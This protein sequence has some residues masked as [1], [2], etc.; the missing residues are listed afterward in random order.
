MLLFPLFLLLFQ[1]CLDSQLD[2]RF[3]VVVP[4]GWVV[5]SGLEERS[6][7][8]EVHGV[9]VWAFVWAWGLVPQFQN[10]KRSKLDPELELVLE[11]WLEPAPKY[12]SDH[13][14]T[15]SAARVASSSAAGE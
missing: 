11:S 8:R 14:K 9:V 15:A 7:R 1:K 6:W 12:R 10:L 4:L 13:A 3:V 2:A 5:D